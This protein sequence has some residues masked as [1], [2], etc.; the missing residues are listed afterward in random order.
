MPGLGRDAEL[1]QL[2][3]GVHHEAQHPLGHRAEVVV[4]ELLALGRL[5]AEQRAPGVDQVR[6]GQEEV[7]VDRKYSCSGRRTKR[8]AQKS[9]WPN[10]FRI[11]SAWVPIACWLRSNGAL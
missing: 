3:L 4:V 8:R 2:A 9:L 1:E 7:P 10:S 11:R 5:G 6:P